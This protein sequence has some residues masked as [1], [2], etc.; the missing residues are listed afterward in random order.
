[1]AEIKQVRCAIYTRKS[2][3]EGLDADFNTLESQRA[4][5]EAYI[6][7]QR[8]WVAL[9]E[10]YDDGGY[11]GA[12]MNRPAMKRLLADVDAGKVDVIVAYKIDRLSRSLRDCLDLLMHLETKGVSFVLVTQ[13]VD[14]TTSMGR[15]QIN[16]LMTFAQYEREMCSDRVRDK[17]SAMKK[18][19]MW[20]GGPMPYGYTSKECHLI[21]IP[22]EAEAIRFVFDQYA[23]IPAPALIARELNFRRI[24]YKKGKE[25]T[26]KAVQ[27]VLSNRLYC[28]I[29]VYQGEAYP[30]VHDAIIT[31][32]QWD[33]AHQAT[34]KRLPYTY[35]KN[36]LE[37]GAFRH[38]VFCASCGHALVVEVAKKRNSFY[39]Y[40]VCRPQSADAHEH[41]RCKPIRIPVK[42]LDELVFA[43]CQK[44]LA[45]SPQFIARLAERM[46]CLSSA[47]INQAITS[48]ESL[49]GELSPLE[50]L[51][52]GQSLVSRIVTS[53]IQ[54]TI[55]LNRAVLGGLV[56]EE[57]MVRTIPLRTI[58][59]A[60]KQ[61]LVSW[62]EGEHFLS[63]DLVIIL[64]GI[65]EARQW[66]ALIAEK[67]MASFVDLANYLK[68]EVKYVTRRLRLALISPRIILALMNQTVAYTTSLNQL[69][70]LAD[71]PWEEQERKFGLKA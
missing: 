49:F 34:K 32:E 36:T 17:V 35:S 45:S 70:D 9:A 25:W 58:R 61:R 53:P 50:Q 12:T 26:S 46:P 44:V 22:Q 1:M 11:S 29:V 56:D 14:T 19:G 43:E 47:K 23:K 28:G 20:T 15:M 63:D 24:P 30:G 68:K 66:V 38:K 60:N 13:N 51:N 59:E 48:Q 40:Y 39:G 62:Q 42:R 21:P 52:L 18:R 8:D 71:L 69:Y 5:C 65:C 67:Q 64:N 31:Q 10:H 33:A 2:V 37:V 7:S 54:L 6:S 4:Y 41:E 57:A 55:E 3:D 16:L 27:T